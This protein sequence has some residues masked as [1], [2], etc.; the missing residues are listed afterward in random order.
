[1]RWGEGGR[2][3]RW[4]SLTDWE[5]GTVISKDTTTNLSQHKPQTIFNI[6]HTIICWEF[7]VKIFDEFSEN[8]SPS[9]E[10]VSIMWCDGHYWV[11]YYCNIVTTICFKLTLEALTVWLC[12]MEQCSVHILLTSLR[13][14]NVHYPVKW[15]KQSVV[16]SLFSSDHDI[17]GGILSMQKK[18]TLPF[19]F[20]TSVQLGYSLSTASVHAGWGFIEH[21]YLVILWK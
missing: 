1:M 15:N 18:W 19:S 9:T 16:T 4:Q 20:G 13:D 5:A 12:V 14:S 17:Q 10:V 7:S 11:F 21:C 6:S 3:G 2:A 8:I